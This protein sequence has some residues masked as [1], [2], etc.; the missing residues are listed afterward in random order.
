MTRATA[1]ATALFGQG[2]HE[3]YA[4]ALRLGGGTL[5]LRPHPDGNHTDE[6]KFDVLSWCSEASPL[7][8]RLLQSLDGPV[9]DIG[10]GPG[11]MLSAAQSLG[12]TALGIDTSGE[13][14]RC[15]RSRGARALEQ[16][17][18][19]AV[20]QSGLWQSMLLL[21]GNIGIGGSISS[22][23][24]RCRQLIARHGTL[25]V[26]VEADDGVDTAYRAVL[27]DGEGNLSQPFVWARGGKPALE[28]R[29]WSTGWTVAS[30]QRIQGRV[31][32]R[33]SPAPLPARSAR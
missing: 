16:S 14:V 8:R 4:R 26:E 1:T 13:A 23:L 18:F 9:L 15:A 27:E 10:C 12:L 21:D 11:R 31:F 29:V 3:P 22:L 2:H 7:E 33:L 5:N 24:R 19:S 25:L 17:V 6:V 28:A 32:C 20:P 30:T